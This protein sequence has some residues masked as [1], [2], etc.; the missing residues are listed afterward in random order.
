ME[1]PRVSA[2]DARLEA[3]PPGTSHARTFPVHIDD[4]EVLLHEQFPT[5]TSI[6]SE[7]GKRPCAWRLVQLLVHGNRQV[8]EPSTTV[9]LAEPGPERFITEPKEIVDVFI[10]GRPEPYPIQRGDYSVAQIL[11]LVGQAPDSYILFEEEDGPPLPVPMDTVVHIAGC[12]IF[13]TQVQ[14]GGSS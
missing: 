9:D 3:I 1:D 10:N 12:E 13:H 7:V 2:G 5:G 6:L 4:R 11:D 14:S 8:I